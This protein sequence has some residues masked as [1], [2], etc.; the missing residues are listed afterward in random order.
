MEHFLRSRSLA[1][2]LFKIRFSNLYRLVRLVEY[3]SDIVFYKKGKSIWNSV[4]WKRL[5]SFDYNVS[6]MQ[7][8]EAFPK[9]KDQVKVEV[10]ADFCPQCF[11]AIVH[12][13]LTHKVGSVGKEERKLLFYSGFW[14]GNRFKNVFSA[15]EVST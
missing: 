8:D 4:S 14:Q 9:Y 6:Q 15:K 12:G 3:K 11:N 13:V 10:Q 1:L 5:K 2:V 7:S